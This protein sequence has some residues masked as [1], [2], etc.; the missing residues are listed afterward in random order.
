MTSKLQGLFAG[1]SSKLPGTGKEVD[2]GHRKKKHLE[3]QCLEQRPQFSSALTQHLRR[4][5]PLSH[6]EKWVG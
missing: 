4:S 2:S 6:V 5:G 1:F 3:V